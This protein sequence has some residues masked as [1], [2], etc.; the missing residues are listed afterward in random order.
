[1][2]KQAPSHVRPTTSA[3]LALPDKDGADP[4]GIATRDDALLWFSAARH[5]STGHHGHEDRASNALL[6]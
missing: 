5:C 4:V 3:L 6:S 1:L 2:T